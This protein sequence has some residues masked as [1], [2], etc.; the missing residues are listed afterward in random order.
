[1]PTA[2]ASTPRT[3]N[4]R[5]IAVLPPPPGR[6]T[7]NRYAACPCARVR[8]ISLLQYRQTWAVTTES[9]SYAAASS[10][11]QTVEIVSGGVETAPIWLGRPLP[12]SSTRRGRIS[13]S[14]CRRRRRGRGAARLGRDGKHR[15]RRLAA[16]RGARR[17]AAGGGGLRRLAPKATYGRP[18]RAVVA[19]RLRGLAGGLGCLVAPTV[20]RARPRA[21]HPTPPRC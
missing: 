2:H 11:L 17:A 6:S 20:A 15:R 10:R 14:S 19:G 4:R 1:M 16:L 9:R 3:M 5:H 13:F 8:P 7:R 12:Y 18:R 21:R